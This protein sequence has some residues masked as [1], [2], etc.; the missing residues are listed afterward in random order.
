MGQINPG[1]VPDFSAQG[2]FLELHLAFKS[3][4]VAFPIIFAKEIAHTE[5]RQKANFHEL[6]GLPRA[7]SD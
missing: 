3:E 2:T 1:S 6:C 5:L 7:L 4:R